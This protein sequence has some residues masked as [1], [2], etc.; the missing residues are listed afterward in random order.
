VESAKEIDVGDTTAPPKCKLLL[1]YILNSSVFHFAPLRDYGFTLR[2]VF[3]FTGS[4][5][6]S[7]ATFSFT[8]LAA[9]MY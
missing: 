5:K 8:R 3:G 1:F 6:R 4:I 2:S 7:T 9:D